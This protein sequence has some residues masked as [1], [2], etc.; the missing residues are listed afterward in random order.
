MRSAKPT[1]AARI[2]LPINPNWENVPL[3]LTGAYDMGDKPNFP[4]AET[5]KK[6]DLAHHWHPFMDTADLGMEDLRLISSAQGSHIWDSD[7]NKILDGMAGLWCVNVGYGRDEISDA[8]AAQMKELPYYNTFFKSTHAPVAALSEKIASIT[9][10]DLNRIFFNTSGSD[11][12]DTVLRIA[13]TYWAAKGKAEK[14]V[15]ITRKNAYH[16]STFAGV[17]LGGMGA[18]HDQGA[19]HIPDIVQ[20]DQPYWFDEGGDMDPEEFGLM[21]ARALEEEIDRLGEDRV[22]AFMAEPIQGAG[23][24]IIPPESYWPEIK[25]ICKERDILLVADEVICGFGRTGEWFGSIHYD[26]EPDMI[27]MAKGLS[28]AYLPIGAVAFSEARAQEMF[29]TAGEFVHG[30]TYSGHPACC[31]AALKNIEIIEREGLITRTRE[32]TAPL[33]AEKLAALSDHPI[34]GEVRTRGLL[35]AIEL[36][37]EKPSRKRFDNYGEIGGLCRDIS[38]KNGLVMRAVRDTMV[39]SPPLVI[40]DAEIEELATKVRLTLDET[41][42]QVS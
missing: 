28:S 15:M 2:L 31:A 25:R 21:R 36:V 40:S 16:G 29:A 19:P 38:F 24:V 13:R 39:M 5:I 11:S 8:A 10:G 4:D 41:W 35:A 3:N 20:I 17:A 14:T 30:Y 12:N 33:F 34:V 18:M 22:A 23:G 1:S 6:T 27:S 32:H 7:G 26:I 9:P 42:E 37:P